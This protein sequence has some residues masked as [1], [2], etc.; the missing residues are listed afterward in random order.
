ML[1]FISILRVQLWVKV[2]EGDLPITPLLDVARQ[3][4]ARPD[5]VIGTVRDIRPA[6]AKLTGGT[7][8]AYSSLS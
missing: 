2:I 7:T 8:P 4:P 6:P 1:C 5:F 3:H